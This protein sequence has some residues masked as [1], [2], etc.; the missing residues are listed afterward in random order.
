MLNEVWMDIPHYDGLYQVSNLGR[1]KALPRER[2]NYQGGRWI[3]PEQIMAT[4]FNEDG[5]ECVSLTMKSG[6]R[7]TERVHRLVALTFIPNPDNKPEVNHI[8]SIRDDNRV[9]NLEWVSRKENIYHSSVYGNKRTKYIKCIE[10]NQIFLTSQ[11]AAD[12]NGGDSG[13][14][15]RAARNQKYSVKGF[16]YIY[17]DKSSFQGIVDNKEQ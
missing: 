9:E 16:H 8:N 1:I 4:R 7:K 6:K 12:T 17:I 13:N 14:I 11:E 10:T 15:R 5:Y 2:V 3:Q